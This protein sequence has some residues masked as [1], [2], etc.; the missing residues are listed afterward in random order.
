MLTELKK[1]EKRTVVLFF[2]DHFPKV[3]KE[4]YE[5]LHGGEFQT[6]KEQQLQHTVPFFIWA[7]YDIAET[8]TQI[9]SLGYL[10]RHLLDA[11]GIPLPPYYQFLKEAEEEIPAVNSLGYFSKLWNTYKPIDEAVGTEKEWLDK[12]QTLQYNNLFDGK[13]RSPLFFGQ[14]LPE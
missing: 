12:Y 9:T 1:V 7:N 14:Y 3:E 13:N 5:A 6:L 10:G 4:F 11:A 8:E 2:G